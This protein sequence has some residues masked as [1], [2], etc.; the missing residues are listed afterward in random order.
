[1]LKK[2]NG[3]VC[4]NLSLSYRHTT[5]LD[6]ICGQIDAGSMV[7]IVGE[8]GCGKSTLMK[9][10]A[11]VIPAAH[12]AIHTS[13]K[14]S[15]VAYLPQIN[16]IDTTFPITVLDFVT[17]GLWGKTGIFKAISDDEISIVRAALQAVG[18]LSYDN[19]LIGTLSGGQLQR[20]RFARLALQDAD[21]FL[22]DE[23]FTAIDE[24]T[25]TDLMCLLHYWHEQG[26][27]IVAVL[28]DTSLVQQQFPQT[29]AL[30]HHQALGWGQ[31][32]IILPLFKATPVLLNTEHE[33]LNKGQD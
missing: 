30:G 5:V 8:N 32:D 33:I 1:M 27:T 25:V 31:T 3:I 28:H 9:A 2:F 29:I 22:L 26:K 10:M 13:F 19:N 23:P 14:K 18:M 15:K 24:H 17:S 20:I 11:G 4:E 21:L 16:T 12:G 7:A 6:N